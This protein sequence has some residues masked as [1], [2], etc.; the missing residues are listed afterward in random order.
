MDQLTLIVERLEWIR[1]VERTLITEVCRMKYLYPMP[2][3]YELHSYIQALQ[4]YLGD[5]DDEKWFIYTQ[6]LL[7]LWLF[8]SWCDVDLLWFGF[9]TMTY[10]SP[11]TVNIHWTLHFI[12]IWHFHSNLFVNGYHDYSKLF[13][14]YLIL[15]SKIYFSSVTI[16]HWR[17]N[18][19]R[20]LHCK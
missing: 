3:T 11:W 18:Q 5:L 7:P 13:V 4:F 14:V 16:V 19:L 1:Q 12:I 17:I 8:C 10:L 2:R 15:S 20:V 6:L 9:G